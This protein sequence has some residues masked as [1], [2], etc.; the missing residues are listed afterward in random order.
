MVNQAS[1]E[2]QA[3]QVERAKMH[4]APRKKPSAS[5][6]HQDLPDPR[7]R[8]V[9]QVA[10]GSQEIPARPDK[11]ADQDPRDL[12]DLRVTQALQE[13]TASQVN[14]ANQDQMEPVELVAQ[15]RKVLVD[16]PAETETQAAQDNQ[17]DLASPEIKARPARVEIR[18]DPDNRADQDSQVVRV[19]PV[20]MPRT[21]RAHHAVLLWL[22]LLPFT[23]VRNRKATRNASV[24]KKPKSKPQLNHSSIDS[25]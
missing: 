9:T 22:A 14:P 8:T 24:S 2:A 23:A 6:A 3:S 16:S 13:T 15:A 19:S 21:A 11:A 1:P 4:R 7:A 18:E 20:Q 10:M 5:A 12:P 17:E 25:L